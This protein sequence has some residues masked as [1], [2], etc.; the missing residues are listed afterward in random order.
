MNVEELKAAR[1]QG[2]RPIAPSANLLGADLRGADL[3][4]ANLCG[5]SEILQITGMP[6]GQLILAPTCDGWQLRVGCWTGTLDEL[7]ALISQ[8]GGWPEAEGEEITRRR[9][10]LEAAL[11]LCEAHTALHPGLIESLVK[12]WGTK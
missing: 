7:R 4:A 1:A 6:S 8:D 12:K 2:L 9:P 5:N 10:I 11:T 3:S